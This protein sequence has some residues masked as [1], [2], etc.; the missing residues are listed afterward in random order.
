MRIV[1][2]ILL[3]LAKDKHIAI[4]L[5]R[6]FSKGQQEKS[7]YK[8]SGSID[9]FAAARSVLVA[10]ERKECEEWTSPP[11]G[12]NPKLIKRRFAVAQQKISLIL[13]KPS[14]EF[15][16]QHDAFFWVGP[17][18]ITADELLASPEARKVNI[19]AV[20]DAKRFLLTILQQ[21]NLETSEIKKQAKK[22]GV[23]PHALEAAKIELRIETRP[24]DGGWSWFLPGKYIAH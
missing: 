8:G 14:V 20:Q 12:S 2:S 16:L 22:A 24:D 11:D 21:G 3:K 1:G 18:L 13:Q 23:D 10:A 19:N 17:S 15:E 7:I 9:L 4:L 5:L 6:H